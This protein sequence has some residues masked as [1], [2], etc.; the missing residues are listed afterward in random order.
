MGVT[1]KILPVNIKV[2]L[3]R[4]DQGSDVY[5]YEL[6]VYETPMVVGRVSYTLLSLRLNPPLQLSSVV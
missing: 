3:K 4:T 2:Q 6:V 5:V 1:S